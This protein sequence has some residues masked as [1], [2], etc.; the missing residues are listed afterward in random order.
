MPGPATVSVV[1]VSR[2]RPRALD[3]CLTGVSQLDYPAFEVIVVACPQGAAAVEAR[4]D[5]DAIKLVAYDEPNISA[6][7]NRGVAQAAGEIVAFL[8][9]DAVPEPTWLHHLTQPFAE[10]AVSAAGGYVRGRNGITYQWKARSVDTRGDTLDIALEGDRPR[11]LQA[12]P[13]QAIKTEG[14]NMAIRRD[15]LA[16]MGGFDP[17][18]R[19]YLDETDVNMRLA[20]AGHGTAIVPL[21]Q[22]HHGFAPSA[23]RDAD[24]TPR[25]LREI[26]ASQ[27]LY[28]RKHCPDSDRDAAWHQFRDRQK[29][30]LLKL[31][32]SGPL[33]AD[34]VLRLLHGLDRG[35]RE[36]MARSPAP[37]RA[38]PHAAQGFL[39]Y[40]VAAGQGAL[41]LGGRTWQRR[42]L[43]SRAMRAR[44]TGRRV[45]LVL[46]S[47]TALYHRVRFCPGGWWEQSGG[48]FGRSDRDQP[49]FRFC[50]LRTRISEETA[51]LANIRFLN[52]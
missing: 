21:A 7:R 42:R 32:Q 19:F 13:G 51:R 16:E 18:F 1:I 50:R 9:D 41:V 26:G 11:L 6:A 52:E 29:R 43:K 2:D 40:T 27:A 15:L 17:G 49:L 44:D 45:T 37:L 12:P 31:M 30:R 34:D 24:R 5:A 20:L 38:L 8:D 46:L 14:T 22:V 39:A 33:G 3:L 47:P 48:Q 28:L 4:S 35:R 23:R 36:G 10:P 25:D